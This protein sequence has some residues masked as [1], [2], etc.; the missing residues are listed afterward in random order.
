MYCPRCGK[1]TDGP[2]CP[3]CGYFIGSR[4]QSGENSN[5]T[6]MFKAVLI[7][8]ITVVV[9][10]ALLALAAKNLNGPLVL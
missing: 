3:A 1:Q 10:A 5:R 9:V 4:K 7:L 8:L 6:G 2:Y